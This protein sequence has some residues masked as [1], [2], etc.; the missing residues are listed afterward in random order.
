MIIAQ[1][2][3]LHIKA[4]GKLAYQQVDTVAALKAAVAHVNQLIPTVDL[5][6]I[7]GDLG[8][9]G[10]PEEYELIA[11]LLAELKMPSLIVP[12]NHDV[13]EPLRDMVTRL[14]NALNFD[15]P[16]FCCT[17]HEQGGWQFIGLDSHVPGHPYGQIAVKQ[18]NW[19]RAQL[20]N[21]DL[22]TVIC[23]HHPPL[24]VGIDH[25]DRQNLRNADVVAAALSGYD[26]IKAIVCGHIHR[27]ITGMF[28]GFPVFV[29]PAHNHAVTLDLAANA[30]SSFSI[31]SPMIRL[32]HLANDTLTSHLSVLP[33]HQQGPYPFFDPAGKLID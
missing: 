13:S 7:T 25:M 24:I 5:V 6:L 22:P 31:E 17:R 8:D 19:L 26:H 18:L 20:T 16:E 33:S 10:Y 32:F 15:H 23:W 28:G 2:S 11:T 27:P 29:A 21:C 12:G 30:P 3:D 1:L 14:P 9:F 4:G